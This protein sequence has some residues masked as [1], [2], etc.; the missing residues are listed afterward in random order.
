MPFAPRLET[1][2]AATPPALHAVGGPLKF[3]GDTI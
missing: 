1:V 3:A 2:F